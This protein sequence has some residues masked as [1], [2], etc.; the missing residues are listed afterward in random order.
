MG[1]RNILRLINEAFTQT[2]DSLNLS[3]NSIDTPTIATSTLT[4][5]TTVS[6]STKYTVTAKTASYAVTASDFGSILTT[7]GAAGAVTFTLPAASGNGGHWVEFY[8]VAD[9]NMIVDGTDEELVVFND[10]TADS[11]S[12]SQSAEKIGG[13]FRAVCDGTS[14]IVVPLCTET[15]TIAIVSS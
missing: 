2:D 12:Y 4:G 15:Q 7:R 8:N 5:V 1:A 14:W 10:L 3:G 13:G 6:G 9:Q 11:I